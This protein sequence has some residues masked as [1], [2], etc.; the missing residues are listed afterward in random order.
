MWLD[1]PRDRPFFL[2]VH[3]FDPHGPYT[4]P[5]PWDTRYY[6]GDP[7][8]PGHHSMEQVAGVAPYLRR[9]IEGIT[10]ADWVLAQYGGEISFADQQ[11]GRLVDAVG[12][13][14]LVVYTA[15]HGEAL[16]EHGVWFNHG[17]DVYAESTLVP[18]ALRFPDRVS[19]GTVVAP[20]VE[21]T[22]VAATILDLVGLPSPLGGASLVPMLAGERGER[23]RARS[24]SIGR[25]TLG[26]G[27]PVPS[28]GRRTAWSRSR[29]STERSSVA[30]RPG[31]STSGAATASHRSKRPRRS[32][33]RS[34]AASAIA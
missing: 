1:R 22:D 33:D 28:I 31:A 19:A 32:S 10:D 17:D 9:S 12:G 34:R 6:A 26:R 11:A 29:G 7:R 27:P 15:D 8:D 30:T 13:D 14:T 3:L 21:L 5:P 20:P 2:W 23:T 4:P 25:R 24:A 18:L 16:G